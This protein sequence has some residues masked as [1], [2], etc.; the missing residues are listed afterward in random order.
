MKRA[1]KSKIVRVFHIFILILHEAKNPKFQ[2]HASD[3]FGLKHFFKKK[4][5]I[6]DYFVMLCVSFYVYRYHKHKCLAHEGL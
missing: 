1:E 2:M 3:F 4:Y 6:A 5:I